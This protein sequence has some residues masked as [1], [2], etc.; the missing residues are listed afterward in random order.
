MI[1]PSI[2]SEVVIIRGG[3]LGDFLL[4]IPILN[5][6]IT[7]YDWVHLFTRG[8]YFKLVPHH[9]NEKVQCHDIDLSPEYIKSFTKG[10]DVISFWND[11]TWITELEEGGAGNVITL[12][13]RPDSS[14][15]IVSYFFTELKWKMED[16]Y[17]L[18]AWLGDGWNPLS[19]T[20]WIH[21]GSGSKKK[22]APLHYFTDRATSWLK[23]N[24]SNQVVF[25]FGE[26]DFS[27][28]SQV[29][30][31]AVSGNSRFHSYEISCLKLLMQKIQAEAVSFLGNDTGPTHMAAMLGVPTEA[32]FI[33]SNPKI[34]KPLGPRVKLLGGE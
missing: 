13:P 17:L 5:K 19:K 25:S 22:N 33:S 18:N 34:W 20:L 15:H 3:G 6:A 7:H 8:Q 11:V 21:P 27:L 23:N 26:A 14:E 28:L 2:I 32:I 30:Q 12:D 29:K 31:L 9:L 16:H 4:T 24:E 1:Q 10:R